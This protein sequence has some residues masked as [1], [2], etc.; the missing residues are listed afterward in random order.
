MSFSS[1]SIALF[2]LFSVCIFTSNCRSEKAPTKDPDPQENEIVKPKPPPLEV[3]VLKLL[4]KEPYDRD[5]IFDQTRSLSLEQKLALVNRLAEEH[6]VERM[7]M[8]K[9]RVQMGIIDDQQIT[10][11]A[12]RE[13]KEALQQIESILR[14]K[15][16]EE[17]LLRK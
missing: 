14:E 11:T 16:Q 3:E 7:N 9:A 2:S 1:K 4:K 8:L 12:K 6:K 10:Q 13:K 17:G 15:A 5:L